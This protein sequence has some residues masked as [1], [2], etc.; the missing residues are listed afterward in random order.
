MKKLW[1]IFILLLLGSLAFAVDVDEIVRK[2]YNAAYYAGEDGRATVDMEIVDKNGRIRERRI[3][4][5]RKDI[6]DG[7][8]QMYY[9]Y[10]KEPSDVK[11]M[12]FM[13]HKNVEKDD[14]RWLYLPALDLVKRIASTDKRSSFVGSD[15]TYE[16]ISGR[17]I[18]E[19]IHQL[20][21]EDSSSY[22]IKNTPKTS[23]DFA[24]FVTYI[25]KKNYLPIKAEYYNSSGKI[26][27]R[28]TAEKV[29]II[30]GFPTITLMKADEIEKG[31]Y[32]TNRFSDVTYNLGM[33][34]DIFT[35]R[36]LRRPPRKWLR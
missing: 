7:R 10:F 34:D 14:D 9:A 11:N 25:D 32:T 33:E 27:R 36:Y 26:Y 31:T 2:A 4:M 28:I 22:I 16:D 6:F 1:L 12:V 21:G 29:E 20:T 23:E 18:T 19:D 15:F 17:S 24:Y 3:I 5:L 30:E 35:E 8:E 13:V